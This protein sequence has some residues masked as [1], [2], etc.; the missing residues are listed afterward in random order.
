M[1]TVPAAFFRR[2]AKVVRFLTDVFYKGH[3]LCIVKFQH[4]QIEV[5]VRVP[6]LIVHNAANPSVMPLCIVIAPVEQIVV[7]F[8]I[9]RHN[10]LRDCVHFLC[11]LFHKATGGKGSLKYSR[12]A[13]I[14]FGSFVITLKYDVLHLVIL[15]TMLHLM[16]SG[17]SSVGSRIG[18]S[19]TDS[20]ALKYSQYQF[21]SAC[22]GAG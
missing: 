8:L 15:S 12:C 5:D 20:P 14:F 9:L 3:I 21:Q 2:D 16:Y 4:S 1:D 13:V 19:D 10:H 7:I 17:I 22:P 6:V 18:Y 11:K